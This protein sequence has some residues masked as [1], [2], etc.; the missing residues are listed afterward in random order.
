MK[1]KPL[2]EQQID[3]G[4]NK[5]LLL[6]ENDNVVTTHQTGKVFISIF[7]YIC[8]IWN[9]KNMIFPNPSIYFYYR[10]KIHFKFGSL[11]TYLVKV[12]LNYISK[13]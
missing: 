12:D 2:I 8:G 10:K 11:C 6:D 9:V 4:S 3:E 1:K 5:V 13:K 7:R